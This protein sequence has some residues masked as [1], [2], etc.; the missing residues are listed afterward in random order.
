M[1][2]SYHI[3]DSLRE[4]YRI[5][6]FL[7]VRKEKKKNLGDTHLARDRKEGGRGRGSWKKAR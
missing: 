4:L 6:V 5:G 2:H 1:A 3:G 7:G